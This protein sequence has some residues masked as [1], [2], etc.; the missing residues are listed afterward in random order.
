MNINPKVIDLYHGDAVSSFE[1]AYKAGIR[2]VIHKAT[3]GA[4]LSDR[5]YARRRVMALDAGMLWGAYHFLRPGD[6][7]GQARRFLDEARPTE[8]T[9]IA[10]D[11]EDT[12]V[13]LAA[14]V[15]FLDELEAA[16][17]R[18]RV[19]YSG[20]SSRSS[21][22]APM[23]ISA[24][25]S[26]NASCGSRITPRRR[27]GRRCGRRRSCGNSPAAAKAPSRIR[28][29]ASTARPTS[30]LSTAATTSSPRNGTRHE[31]ISRTFRNG[32]Q[33]E[34]IQ[35]SDRKQDLLGRGDVA[36]RLWP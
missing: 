31:R 35:A 17:I 5:A 9:L 27:D 30:A 19:V 4:T 15:R 18:K 3:E 24:P 26:R 10:V 13:P 20:F 22:P 29:P 11:H 16:G 2:G 36:C 8:A 12:R 21:F 32:D 33:N 7:A 34:R 1:D 14:L 6:P 25:S 28:R 23:I